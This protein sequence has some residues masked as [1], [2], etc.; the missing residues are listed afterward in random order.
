MGVIVGGD[1]TA[2]PDQYGREVTPYASLNGVTDFIMDEREVEIGDRISIR[3]GS[4]KWET[5]TVDSVTYDATDNSLVSG[6]VVSEPFDEA[7][8]RKIEISS[9]TTSVSDPSFASNDHNYFIN[10]NQLVFGSNS[11][12]YYYTNGV[13][14]GQGQ[15]SEDIFDQHIRPDD[16]IFYKC[17]TSYK[18]LIRVKRTYKSLRTIE[19]YSDMKPTHMS[20]ACTLTVVYNAENKGQGTME[21]SECSGRGL[22]DTDTG[23]CSCFKGYMGHDCSKQNSLSF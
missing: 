8:D 11:N 6:F 12:V 13:L 7:V 18:G 20:G 9:T 14:N 3:T 2:R 4:G 15:V 10:A 16:Y 19:F 22:C 17:G 23:V 21:A 5:R 1:K